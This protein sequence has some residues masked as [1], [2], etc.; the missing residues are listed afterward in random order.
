[1]SIILKNLINELLKDTSLDQK[2]IIEMFN[3]ELKTSNSEEEA[4]HNV[5]MRIKFYF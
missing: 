1:M 4:A 5:R 2:Q 3:E